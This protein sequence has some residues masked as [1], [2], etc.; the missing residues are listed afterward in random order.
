VQRPGRQHADV[1]VSATINRPPRPPESWSRVRTP[2][3]RSRAVP[4]AA[5]VTF[6]LPDRNNGKGL[7]ARVVDSAVAQGV[8]AERRQPAVRRP[9]P[10]FSRRVDGVL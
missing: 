2:V 7:I 8:A 6:V 5:D 1:T 10:V 4:G 3:G 9:G